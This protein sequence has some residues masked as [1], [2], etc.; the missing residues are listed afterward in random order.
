MNEMFIRHVRI[1]QNCH[2]CSP[3]NKFKMYLSEETLACYFC[4]KTHLLTNYAENEP[5]YSPNSQQTRIYHH[6]HVTTYL[7]FP[8]LSFLYFLFFQTIEK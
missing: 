1:N 4:M 7:S 8:F 3:V 2:D 6:S 5:H